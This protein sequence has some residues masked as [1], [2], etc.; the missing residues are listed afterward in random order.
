MMHR[1]L[2]EIGLD[3]ATSLGVRNDATFILQQ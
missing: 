1:W 3:Q 2:D